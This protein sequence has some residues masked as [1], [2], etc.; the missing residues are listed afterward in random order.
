MPLFARISKRSLKNVPFFSRNV[1]DRIRVRDYRVIRS[2][3]PYL[4]WNCLVEPVPNMSSKF[5][6]VAVTVGCCNVMRSGDKPGT[7]RSAGD[8]Y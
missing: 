3:V 6:H 5:L 8:E 4:D 7:S 2:I 1:L